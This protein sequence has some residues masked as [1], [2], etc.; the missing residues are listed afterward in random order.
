[1]L[2]GGFILRGGINPPPQQNPRL[3]IMPWLP[4]VALYSETVRCRLLVDRKIKTE[5]PA[6]GQRVGLSRINKKS[7]LPGS[8]P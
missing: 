3:K 6:K 1:M 8:E 2:V 7:A 5:I 4:A